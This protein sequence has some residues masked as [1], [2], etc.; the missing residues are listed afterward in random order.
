MTVEGPHL[1]WLAARHQAVLVTLRADGSPQTSNI[2]YALYDGSARVS[3]TAGRAKTRNLARDGRGVLHV[4]GDSFWSYASVRVS[5]HLGPATTT[6]GDE[7]G[8]ELLEVYERI[9][10]APHPDPAE[11]FDAM[12]AEQR[13]VVRLTPLSVVGMGIPSSRRPR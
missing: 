5:A 2:A 1:D 6:A 3:V 7:A 13:L 4:L 10:G 11:F 12:V 9:T 8:R